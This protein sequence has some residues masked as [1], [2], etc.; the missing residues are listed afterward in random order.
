VPPEPLPDDDDPELLELL[1]DDDE[2]P[3]LVELLPDDGEDPELPELLPDDGELL[4]LLPDD[5][6]PERPELLA[7]DGPASSDPGSP[8]P[9]LEHPAPISKPRPAAKNRGVLERLIG[10]RRRLLSRSW[11]KNRVAELGPR[12]AHEGVPA[13][14]FLSLSRWL[15]RELAPFHLLGCRGP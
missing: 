1:P 5:G 10:W 15:S 3:E 14:C 6:D 9:E 12:A 7:D 11:L 8:P 4:E 13:Q 2:D